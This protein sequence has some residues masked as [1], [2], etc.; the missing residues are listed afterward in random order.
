MRRTT[1]FTPADFADPPFGCPPDPVVLELPM[2]PSVNATRRK[3][4]SN[5]ARLKTWVQEADN[6]VLAQGL[7]RAIMGPFEIHILVS[8]RCRKQFQFTVSRVSRICLTMYS[9]KPVSLVARIVAHGISIVTTLSSMT[10]PILKLSLARAASIF[11]A[12]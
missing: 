1:P 2:P 10:M 8:N 4:W 6:L 3:D 9:D 7:P 11:S 5:H 12:N